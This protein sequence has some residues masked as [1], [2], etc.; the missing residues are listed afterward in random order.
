[1]PFALGSFRRALHP[2]HSHPTSPIPPP[3]IL[4]P[5][6][7]RVKDLNVRTSNSLTP[8]FLPELPIFGRARLQSCRNRL[9][10]RGVSP[11]EVRSRRIDATPESMLHFL[12]FRRTPMR[13]SKSLVVITL[14]LAPLTVFAQSNP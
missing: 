8:R 2:L 10:C 7:L 4:N 6:R 3:A 5:R 14:S 12:L 1:M 9:P 13:I 11:P